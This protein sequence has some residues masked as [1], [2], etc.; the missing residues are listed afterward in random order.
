MRKLPNSLVSA[1]MP[2]GKV[3]GTGAGLLRGKFPIAMAP[4]LPEGQSRK[5]FANDILRTQ[6]QGIFF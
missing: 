2:S 4:S 3:P 1:M 6:V 5:I